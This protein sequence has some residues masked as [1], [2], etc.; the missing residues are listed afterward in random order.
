MGRN[1]LGAAAV[2][3][4]MAALV[5]GAIA[6]RGPDG[7][8]GPSAFYLALAAFDPSLRAAALNSAAVAAAVAAGSIVVGV[9]LALLGRNRLAGLGLLPMAVPPM[10]GALGLALGARRLG[11][12][13]WAEGSTAGWGVL[14]AAYLGP[15]SAWVARGASERLS[16]VD[17]SWWAASRASGS[18]AWRVWWSRAWPIVRPTAARAGAE[19]FALCVFEPGAPLLLG[20]RRTLAFQAVEAASG[21][22]PGPRSATLG[23]AALLLAALA[24]RSLHVWARDRRP[25]LPR[26]IEPRAEGWSSTIGRSIPLAIWVALSTLPVVGLALGAIAGASPTGPGLRLAVEWSAGIGVVGATLGLLLG[27]SAGG[28]L[29]P[30]LAVG[31]GALHV[32]WLLEV[33]GIAVGPGLGVS[34]GRLPAWVL[35]AWAVGATTRGRW[36]ADGGEPTSAAAGRPGRRIARGPWLLAATWGAT[37]AASA[38]ILAPTALGPELLRLADEPG[39]ASTLG[40]GMIAVNLVALVLAGGGPGRGGRRRGRMDG[41]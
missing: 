40:L 19:V 6:D 34:A 22:T 15:G 29:L 13:P 38:F 12:D 18:S 9:G 21:A 24:G 3:V 11:F 31:L 16:R 20:L 25:A 26:P 36:D 2:A 5:V 37:D 30:P 33:V 17:P 41:G 4:P 28:S 32:P 14:L 27:R 23:V 7:V 8:R 1:W 39:R 10:V 35:L